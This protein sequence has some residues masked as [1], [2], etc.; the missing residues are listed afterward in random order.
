VAEAA[1]RARRLYALHAAVGPGQAESAAQEALRPCPGDAGLLCAPAGLWPRGPGSPGDE[2]WLQRGIRS[3]RGFRNGTTVALSHG[4]FQPARGDHYDPTPAFESLGTPECF[5]CDLVSYEEDFTL[6]LAPLDVIG[7]CR[8]LFSNLLLDT[9]EA[10]QLASFQGPH[11][12]LVEP[13]IANA[14]WR[15]Y[16]EEEAQRLRDRGGARSIYSFWKQDAAC[17]LRHGSATAFGD[18]FDWPALVRWLRAARGIRGGV[19][20]PAFLR[21]TGGSLD[22]LVMLSDLPN[23]HDTNGDRVPCADSDTPDELNFFGVDF[24]VAQRVCVR[25]TAQ[26][27]AGGFELRFLDM[28]LLA[29]A[30]RRAVARARAEGRRQAAVGLYLYWVEGAERARLHPGRY[31]KL[32]AH[33]EYTSLWRG[34]Q[35]A[36]PIRR[37]AS[38]ALRQ[39]GLEGRRFLAAHWRRG[40]WF[41]GPHPRKLEQAALAEAPHFAQVIRGH[42]EQQGLDR[43]FLMTNAAPG[44][45]DVLALA[46]ELEGATVVQAPVLKGDHQ[47]LRQLCIEMAVAIAA[48]F[49]VAFGDGLV[50]GMA[51]MPSLLVLQARLHAGGWPLESNAFAFVQPHQNALGI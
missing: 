5:G 15:R 43:V 32:S 4:L 26:R 38:L 48:D 30:V 49:F 14:V 46:R 51:S 17:G 7:P 29:A 10:L 22:L 35:F 8:E 42:L 33:S 25:S 13:R 20:W 44:S 41:L 3:G 27:H 50:Q 12:V 39:L 23:S 21:Q 36:P 40:D 1:A 47:N 45:A 9:L 16:G 24:K 34:L 2:V 18:L 19:T 31:G 28:P 37:R 11:A 6:F